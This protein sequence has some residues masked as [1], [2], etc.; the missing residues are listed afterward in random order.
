MDTEPTTPA[1][2]DQDT[3]ERRTRRS[4]VVTVAVPD[5]IVALATLTNRTAESIIEDLIA[6]QVAAI[7]T[8][9]ASPLAQV[10]A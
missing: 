1:T 9:A 8:K 5:S 6:A 7:N 4:R 2:T 3:P 10:I